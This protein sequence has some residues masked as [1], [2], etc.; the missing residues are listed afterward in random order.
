MKT[1]ANQVA[2]NQL[3]LNENLVLAARYGDVVDVELQLNAG[4]EVLFRD[5]TGWNSLY[6]AASNNHLRVAE[7]LLAHGMG[8]SHKMV[9]TALMLANTPEMVKLLAQYHP[10]C[11]VTNEKGFTGRDLMVL[12]A[13]YDLIAAYGAC[14]LPKPPLN[15]KLLHYIFQHCDLKRWSALTG[16]AVPDRYYQELNDLYY[17]SK[18]Q[19]RCF[20]RIIKEVERNA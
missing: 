4:A 1:Q 18:R 15:L 12:N 16:T 20:N 3:T 6:H 2:S 10:D 13:E 5:D 11:T 14:G 19:Q 9:G 7:L 8:N 17:S